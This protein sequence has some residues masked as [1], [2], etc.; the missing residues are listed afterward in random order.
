MIEIKFRAWII[1][2]KKMV[3][4]KALGFDFCTIIGWKA[5]EVGVLIG[6]PYV[7]ENSIRSGAK[8]TV[9]VANHHKSVDTCILMQFTGLK[10]KNEKDIYVGDIMKDTETG[11]V[12]AVDFELNGYYCNADEIGDL[13]KWSIRWGE[14]IGNIHENPELLI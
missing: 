14:I 6:E 7:D 12:G 5:P 1:R 10:D 13:A 4:V 3:P 2:D 11:L 8:E 9:E